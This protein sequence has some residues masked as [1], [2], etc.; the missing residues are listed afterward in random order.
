MILMIPA[1]PSGECFADGLVITSIFSIEPAGICC[2]MSPWLSAVSPLALPL[3]Q[4]VTLSLPRSDTTPSLSTSTDGMSTSTSL[5]EPPV[6]AIL[7]S[8]VKTRLSISKLICER[9]SV[10]TTSLSIF[11]SLLRV[12][13]PRS[14]LFLPDV[15]LTLRL[16]LM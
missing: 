2:R 14:T 12:I 9:C 4:I 6:E 15:M 16:S 11:L 8:T 10:T 13:W 1:V 3:I 7:W 5:A